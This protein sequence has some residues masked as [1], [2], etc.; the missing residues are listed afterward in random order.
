MDDNN[1]CIFD[2]QLI[3]GLLEVIKC[4]HNNGAMF[5]TVF[6]ASVWIAG[7]LG[8]EPPNCFLNPP[9]TQSNYVLGVSYILYTYSLHH[10]FG[11][12]PTVKKFNPQ[13]IF[14]NSNTVYSWYY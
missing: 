8:V 4:M 5:V 9:N 12:A 14:H 2:L 10:N 7:G 6:T 11:R 13:L 1:Y 3:I